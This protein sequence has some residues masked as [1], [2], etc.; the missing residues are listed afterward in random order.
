MRAVD[1]LDQ[2]VVRTDHQESDDG[3][4]LELT[5][6]GRRGSAGCVL[7]PS[8]SPLSSLDGQATPALFFPG[9]NRGL[10]TSAAGGE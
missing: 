10:E 3:E 8:R 2:V 4:D 6:A 7:R 1:H 9:P 5:D